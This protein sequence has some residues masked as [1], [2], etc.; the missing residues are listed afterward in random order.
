VAETMVARPLVPR[1]GL[2]PF[3]S[4]KMEMLGTLLAS[5]QAARATPVVAFETAAT[6]TV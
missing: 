4:L 1:K 2:D 5:G 6:A 3:L